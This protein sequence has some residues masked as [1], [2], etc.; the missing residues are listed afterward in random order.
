MSISNSQGV[1]NNGPRK[2]AYDVSGSG[3]DLLLLHGLSSFRERWHTLGYVEHFALRFR[4]ITMDFAG[5]GE[6]SK[7]HDPQ[8]YAA[9]NVVDDVEAVLDA[10]GAERPI[11]VGF[12]YGGRLA[13]HLSLRWHLKAVIAL[14]AR[15]GPAMSG[16]RCGGFVA[17]LDRIIGLIDSGTF[18][19]DALSR[20]FRTEIERNDPKAVRECTR[21]FGEW[22][23][24][25]PSQITT[26]TAFLV[27]DRDEER[28]QAYHEWHGEMQR[29]PHITAATL[30]GADH[31]STFFDPA[32]L[33]PAVERALEGFV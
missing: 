28:I 25:E 22:P 9:E 30:P 26:P 2:I 27:G 4:V 24:L 12:S 13:L 16:T 20:E 15:F 6:S 32:V 5:H 29:N 31:G 33:L 23:E 8:A 19:P 10:A 18:D 14:G 21:S 3:P 7:P 17:E 11:V 1:A